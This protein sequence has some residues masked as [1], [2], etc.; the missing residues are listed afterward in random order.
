MPLTAPAGTPSR[1]SPTQPA[2]LSGG[3]PGRGDD[4][5]RIPQQWQHCCSSTSA[6]APAARGR[7]PVAAASRDGHGRRPAAPPWVCPCRSALGGGLHE[8][9]QNKTQVGGPRMS[10]VCG[11]HHSAHAA[12]SIILR[13]EDTRHRPMRRQIGLGE[14]EAAI[15]AHHIAHGSARWRPPVSVHCSHPCRSLLTAADA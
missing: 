11:L 12:I 14:R 13:T 1:H 5:E 8:S 4:D 6:C 3:G 9:H 7:W 15:R 10:P 2:G